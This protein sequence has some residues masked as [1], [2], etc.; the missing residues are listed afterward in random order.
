MNAGFEK[1]QAVEAEQAVLGSILIDPK[2]YFLIADI[3]TEADFMLN[4]HRGI[5]RAIKVMHEE[6][7]AIDV[8]TVAE[9]LK[10]NRLL[11][12]CGD[13]PYLVD[14]ASSTPGSANIRAWAEL[15]AKASEKRRLMVAGQRIHSCGSFTEAQAILSEVRPNAM[16]RVKTAKEAAKAMWE[17]MEKRS[18]SDGSLTGISSTI[19]G[20]D[21]MTAGFQP[22]QLVVVAGRPG[23]GKSV[24]AVQFMAGSGRV[25]YASL[26]MTDTELMERVVANVGNIPHRW[27]RN[28]KE[29]DDSEGRMLNALRQVTQM[30]FVLDERSS[31]TV[32]DICARTR[33]LHME[34]PL[35]ALVVDHL[36]LIAR[37][38][39]NDAAELGLV[40]KALKGLAKD[41]AIPVILLCQLNRKVTDRA[42]NEPV[43]SDLRDS[44]RIEEDADV[45]IL[46][47]RPEYYKQEPAGYVKFIVGK[48]RSGSVGD[49][50]A[51]SRL[52]T[53]RLVSAE[54]PEIDAAKPNIVR[55]F[56]R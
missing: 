53:M 29:M 16:T 51:L 9:W 46:M 7:K 43:I 39:R 21:A 27:M 18:L 26:E 11:N 37:P 24:W 47:H 8:I 55:G 2:S 15:V 50:W 56:G 3:L 14:L 31:M 42:G 25:F 19:D 41:L 30:E 34:K 49:A 52:A 28:P 6:S 36:G 10:A 4:G 48:N 32:D 5:Y 20:V 13:G 17:L 40:T 35:A 54:A 38:G 33:Q 23:M 12:E 22:G 44:G 45:V 1:H